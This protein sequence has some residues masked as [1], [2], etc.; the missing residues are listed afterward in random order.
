MTEQR[1]AAILAPG[2]RWVDANT[3]Q[4]DRPAPPEALEGRELCI[5]DLEMSGP[6]PQ[7]HEILDIGAVRVS[8]EEGLPE[9]ASFGTKV[10]P[11]HIGTANQASLRI[12]GYSP[13]AWRDAVSLEDAVAELVEFGAG[14][15]LAGWGIRLDLA[16]LFEAL[17]RTGY[18]WPFA[19]VVLDV[20]PVAQAVL[21]DGTVDSWNLGHVA[22]RLGIGRLGE[23]G[24]LADA[25][26]AYDVLAKL[27]ELASSASEG[28]RKAARS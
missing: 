21:K 16:F 25:Y 20:Q 6:D 2:L 23:H 10:R 15:V 12:V 7:V 19:D 17:E 9:E 14:A 5:L 11:K 26:A 3:R 28:E 18:E 22:D 24:A 13:K 8:L 4:A 27:V 1:L